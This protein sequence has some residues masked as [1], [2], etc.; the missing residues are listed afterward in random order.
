MKKR[1]IIILGTILCLSCVFPALH[2]QGLLFNDEDYNRQPR[3]P[4]YDTGSKADYE[5]VQ[6]INKI[7]LK[8]FCPEPQDQ[9]LIAS[10]TG[11]ACGYGALTIMQAIQ[12]QWGGQRDSI[13]RNA[14]SALFIFNQIKKG[15]CDFGA[16]I[17][18]AAVLLEEKGNI[19]SKD[20][21][22]IKNDCERKPNPDEL[23][24]AMNVRIKDHVTLFASDD[25]ANIKIGETK[26]CLSQKMPVIVGIDLLKSFQQLPKG[27]EFWY[28]AGDSIPVGGHAVVVVGFDDGREAFEILNSWGTNWAN[29][30]FAWI[31]YKDFAKYCRYGYKLIP[32]NAAAQEKMAAKIMIK[33]PDY[34]EDGHLFF[35][36]EAI[37][38]KNG[39]YELASGVIKKNGLLQPFVQHA[40]KNSYLY[41]FSY[42]TRRKISVHWPRDEKLDSRFDGKNE[43]A[44]L[45][46]REINL[47]I[48]GPLGALK[49]SYSGTE[50]L[51]F[52]ISR[53]PMTQFN[54]HIIALADLPSG[55][56]LKNLYLSFGSIL[57]PQ[58]QIT[59]ARDA[60][61]C[62]SQLSKGDAIPLVLKIKIE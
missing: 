54:K 11:W 35:T 12:N 15:S 33:K 36:Q 9:G 61:D 56:F 25:A 2:S 7:D 49:F 50:Y 8:P 28:P 21:D 58:R 1:P 20:F 48:P 41:I 57:E 55:D 5:A 52:V 30:G 62:Q 46:Q 10:C 14:F 59:C 6:N 18:D 60:M 47:A 39:Y 34:S 22:R 23:E 32:A 29:Q 13:T 19:L 38:Y 16:Y 4:A 42:D 31:K 53:K 3:Q 44:I 40:T 37:V 45:T 24:K 26:L 51:C 43:S 17:S 27:A